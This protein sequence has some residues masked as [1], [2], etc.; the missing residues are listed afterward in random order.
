M[1]STRTTTITLRVSHQ[2]LARI[3]KAAKHAGQDR[4]TYILQWVPEYDG[5]VTHRTSPAGRDGSERPI[6]RRA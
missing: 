4:N 3:D 5:D 2:N 6:I 1:T